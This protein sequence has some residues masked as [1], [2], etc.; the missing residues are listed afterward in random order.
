MPRHWTLTLISGLLCVVLLVGCGSNTPAAPTAANTVA[1]TQPAPTSTTTAIPPTPTRAATATPVPPTPTRVPPTA[2]PLPLPPVPTLTTKPAPNASNPLTKS[3]GANLATLA[4]G[5]HS[6]SGN[7][8][9]LGNNSV[10]LK[11]Y[12]GKG[13]PFAIL[14]PSTW[15][16]VDLEDVYKRVAFVSPD[17]SLTAIVVY[18]PIPEWSA[19]DMYSA[20]TSSPN[21]ATEP[22]V[23]KD[24]S[25][26]GEVEYQTNNGTQYYGVARGLASNG[27]AY[28]VMI[29]VTPPELF[30]DV[31]EFAV[32]MA[33]SLQVGNGAA[34]NAP[35]PAPAEPTPTPPPPPP[36]PTATPRPEFNVSVSYRG[37]ADW[38]RPD[39]KDCNNTNDL[40]KVRQLTWDIHVTNTSG[41]EITLDDWYVPEGYSNTGAKA[42]ALCYWE[43][44]RV[45]PGQTG[46][47]TF[48]TYVER[49]QYVARLTF[50]IR[51]TTYT[52]CLDASAREVACR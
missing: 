48:E 27:I 45:A 25:V 44:P 39:P 30:Q 31:A 32:I 34:N 43:P 21:R 37:Y 50:R 7:K 22:I 12:Q 2:T 33:V 23:L 41:K 29:G 3:S 35:A 26:I 15:K 52:R 5:S 20:L 19:A 36:P 9:T 40:Q 28:G 6:K 38:G 18:V 47:M 10:E 24:G 16:V 49:G 4:A 51:N 11:V 14:Y 17:E 42:L 46:K 8:Q 13:A 1:P